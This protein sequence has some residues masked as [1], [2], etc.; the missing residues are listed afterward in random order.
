MKNAEGKNIAAPL[1]VTKLDNLETAVVYE[2]GECTAYC[3]DTSVS[4]TNVK[5]VAIAV[6]VYGKIMISL[7][8]VY[9]SANV[10]EGE[11]VDLSHVTGGLT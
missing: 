3:S 5:C 1:S 11:S 8:S 4:S 10:G 6:G 2:V 7:T 9:T